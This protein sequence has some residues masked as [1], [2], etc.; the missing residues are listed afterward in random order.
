[1][2][3][4]F[5]CGQGLW[6]SRLWLERTG[7]DIAGIAIMKSKA[8]IIPVFV[9][10]IYCGAA[11]ILKQEMLSL[12][13]DVA[14]HKYTINCKIEYTDVL[15]LGTPK[16][17]R[18]LVNKLK[19]QMWGLKDLAKALI[20]LLSNMRK[21]GTIVPQELVGLEGSV[22]RLDLKDDFVTTLGTLPLC[23]SHSDA[24]QII[25]L[26]IDIPLS[27]L[28]YSKLALYRQWILAV[29][30]KGHQV[31]LTTNDKDM[32]FLPLVLKAD[33]FRKQ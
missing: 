19:A 6:D 20:I 27:A 22:K 31:F 21:V 33:F 9:E 13:G 17:Y 11:N 26:N 32:G 25:G 30:S 24:S 23:P 10:N 2:F 29:Q 28:D 16:E 4:L 12:G 7:S 8:D 3:N 5:Y 1:M 18:L 14:V 15:I